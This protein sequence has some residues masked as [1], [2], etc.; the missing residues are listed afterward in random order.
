MFLSRPSII[1][2]LR[3]LNSFVYRRCST[4]IK[5]TASIT[6]SG[7]DEVS[8]AKKANYE[9]NAPTIFDKIL[10]KE[11]KA[12][13]IYEDKLCMAFNDVSPQA[14]VHF[15]VIPKR[16]IAKLEHGGTDDI[17]VI[18]ILQIYLMLLIILLIVQIYLVCFKSMYAGI[19]IRV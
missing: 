11:I 3:L 19:Q 6:M 13:I 5:E 7:Q 8:K 1:P 10:S 12:E 18:M 15:L 4:V 17:E 9:P 2:K 14:P 16:K